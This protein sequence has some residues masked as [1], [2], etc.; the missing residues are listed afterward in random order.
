M[1]IEKKAHNI[2]V[3]I[4]SKFLREQRDYN[5]NFDWKI[6]KKIVVLI[7]FGHSKTIKT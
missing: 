7:Y 5:L 4:F 6:Q 1:K 3:R 2:C